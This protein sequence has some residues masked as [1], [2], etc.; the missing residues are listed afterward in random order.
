M[1]LY[2]RLV[3]VPVR[4]VVVVDVVIGGHQGQRDGGLGGEDRRVVLPTVGDI[5][6]NTILN[7]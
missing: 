6:E 5:S 4:T 2:E 3:G 1:L 7:K